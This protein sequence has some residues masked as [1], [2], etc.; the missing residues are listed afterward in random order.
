MKTAVIVGF[1]LMSSMAFSQGYT[2]N[3]N[4]VLTE[5]ME[6]ESSS[7]TPQIENFKGD[8]QIEFQSEKGRNVALSDAFFDFVEANRSESEEVRIDMGNNNTLVIASEAS[9]N[10]NG[11]GPFNQPFIQKK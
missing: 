1:V 8:F 9:L 7:N 5:T 11:E 3:C 4:I 6:V 2:K 10:T